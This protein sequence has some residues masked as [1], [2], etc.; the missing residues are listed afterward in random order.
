MK[1]LP[2]FS[3]IGFLAFTSIIRGATITV[4]NDAP[5]GPGSLTAAINALNDGDTIAFHIPP[6]TGEVH[7]IKTPP[8]GYPLITRNNITIDG[9]TQGGAAPNTSPIHAANNA[10]LKIVLSSTNGNALSMY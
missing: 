8:D 1:K 6:E 5:T 2:A 4:T 9:Y 3:L 7:Y 10:S